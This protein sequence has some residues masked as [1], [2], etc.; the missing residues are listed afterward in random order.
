[1]TRGQVVKQI[2]R[3]ELDLLKVFQAICKR[4]R[5]RY[6]AVGGTCLGAVRYQGFIP[7]EQFHGIPWY[8]DIDVVMP[9]EDYKKFLEA[10]KAELQAPYAVTHPMNCPEEP[11]FARLR[12]QDASLPPEDTQYASEM[13]LD[14]HPLYGAPSGSR[15]SFFRKLTHLKRWNFIMRF[16]NRGA[17]LWDKKWILAFFGTRHYAYFTGKLDKLLSKRP[18][19]R[20]KEVFFWW[21]RLPNEASATDPTCTQ[22]FTHIFPKHIFQQAIEVPFEDTVI[23]IPTGYE[24]YLTMDFGDLN[25]FPPVGVRVLQ[26][27]RCVSYAPVAAPSAMEP[28]TLRR[29]QLA[30]LELLKVFQGICKKY[31]LRYFAIGGTCIGAIRHHGF[32]PWDDDIDVAMPYEDLVKFLEIAE[33]ELQ[34]PYSVIHPLNCQGEFLIPRLQNE[35]TTSWWEGQPCWGARI[36]IHKIHGLPEGKWQQKRLFIVLK[37]LKRCNLFRR[38]QHEKGG[39]RRGLWEKAV[40]WFGRSRP[41]Y[42]FTI[43]QDEMLRKFSFDKASNVL[44]VC[45]LPLPNESG[46]GKCSPCVLSQEDFQEAIEV[47]FEDTTI[48][49]PVGYDHHLRMFFG[50][51]MELPPVE[52]RT[53]KHPQFLLDLDKPYGEYLAGGQ[54]HRNLASS[55]K[56]DSLS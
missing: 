4:H 7:W 35:A 16:R 42:Y 15:E 43:K 49:V 12:N 51:Y 50:D 56:G 17:G 37:F 8:D 30:G 21:R 53:P 31:S 3:I 24:K 46:W 47:P 33:R 5:L 48:A 9:D 52:A 13:C 32:I 14:I 2:Q 36:D 25:T 18:F 38:L 55:R 20:A 45:Y 26:R 44:L 41:F 19:E 6:F 1:M 27:R 23:A 11:L 54:G 28:D 10:A 22:V 29:F 39:A 34:Y 40:S